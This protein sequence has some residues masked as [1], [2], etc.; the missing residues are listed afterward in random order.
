M[1]DTMLSSLMVV[2]Q[3]ESIYSFFFLSSKY[4]LQGLGNIRRSK[5]YPFERCWE[6]IL[7]RWR[8]ERYLFFKNFF[9][10][11]WLRYNIYEYIDLSNKA[12]DPNRHHELDRQ[13]YIHYDS[14][15]FMAIIKAS[16]IAIMDG[17][18]STY[19]KNDV[20]LNSLDCFYFFFFLFSLLMIFLKVF[21]LEL[22]IRP[23]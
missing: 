10:L 15:R 3:I 11:Q 9:F 2:L 7:C 21:H 6:R 14:L 4:I 19:K 22:L 5:N 8:C 13:V 18:T 1:I 20:Y 17:V 12:T 16:Y 23:R